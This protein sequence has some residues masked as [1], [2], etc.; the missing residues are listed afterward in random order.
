[1]SICFAALRFIE[2]NDVRVAS[3]VRMGTVDFSSLI[4]MAAIIGRGC[5]LELD[6]GREFP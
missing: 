4:V 3:A 5:W 2:T 1:M 6:Q